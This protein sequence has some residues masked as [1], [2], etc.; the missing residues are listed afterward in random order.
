MCWE[1]LAFW[2]G[3]RHFPAPLERRKL[4]CSRQ[5]LNFAQSELN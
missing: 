4:L 2:R 5:L 3:T 1:S